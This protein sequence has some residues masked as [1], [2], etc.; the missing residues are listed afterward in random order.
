[1]T[2]EVSELLSLDVYRDGGSL[3][4]SFRDTE[5][6]QHELIFTID[7]YAS[8]ETDG[9]KFYKSASIESY[10]KS[11]YV[12]PITGISSPKTE[13]HKASISWQEAITLLSN[14]KRFM[15]GFESEYRWVFK[16][17]VEVAG[18]EQH[19]IKYS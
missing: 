17:M 5:G 14:L 6:T 9:F 18:N 4:A 19:Q 15:V 10:I 16:S 12:S 2:P 13:K 3:S 1:M 11:E 7:N 8:D